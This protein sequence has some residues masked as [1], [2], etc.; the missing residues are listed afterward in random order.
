MKEYQLHAMFEA[1]IRNHSN[2]MLGYMPICAAGKN[3]SILHYTKND[4]DID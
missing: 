4:T 2:G 1:Y 3:C